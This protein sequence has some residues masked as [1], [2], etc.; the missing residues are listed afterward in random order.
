M[1]VC[2]P[3]AVKSDDHVGIS[4]AGGE[5]LAISKSSRNREL[6]AEFVRFMVSAVPNRKFASAV[7]SPTPA[8]R[9]AV[10]PIDAQQADKLAETF[11]VQ[12]GYSRMPPFHPKWV[13]IEEILEKAVEKAI[14]HKSTPAKA[15]AEATQQ[16]NSIVAE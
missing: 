11:V 9:S 10:Q 8:N 2:L 7:G 4:F 13:Y 15:L 1:T 12:L 16:I 3:T 6:A 14:Y 5:Y